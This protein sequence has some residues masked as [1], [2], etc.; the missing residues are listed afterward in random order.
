MTVCYSPAAFIAHPGKG[1]PQPLQIGQKE[2]GV[3]PHRTIS[4][5]TQ[6]QSITLQKHKLK[7][8]RGEKK[9]MFYFAVIK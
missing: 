5:V 2:D 4:K 8:K 9:D 3:H 1:N 6:T 7:I